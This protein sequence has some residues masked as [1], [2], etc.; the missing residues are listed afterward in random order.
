MDTPSYLSQLYHGH[1]ESMLYV[2]GENTLR[3]VTTDNFTVT[4]NPNADW[5]QP[6]ISLFVFHNGLDLW[7]IG[8][9]YPGFIY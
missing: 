1:N 6:F 3:L 8:P 5:R 2:Y 9:S 7:G 4:D